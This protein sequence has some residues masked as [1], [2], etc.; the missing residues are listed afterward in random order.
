MEKFITEIKALT[1]KPTDTII[2]T[3]TEDAPVDVAVAFHNM[4][5]TLFPNNNVLIQPTSIISNFKIATP[6]NIDDWRAE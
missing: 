4:V 3:L 5:K 1:I 2:L 6:H